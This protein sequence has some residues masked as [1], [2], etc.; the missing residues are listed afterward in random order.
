MP[1]TAL[2]SPSQLAARRKAAGGVPRGQPGG[3][4]GG[5]AGRWPRPSSWLTPLLGSVAVAAGD[6]SRCWPC[7]VIAASNGQ[8]VGR[9]PAILGLCL[10]ALFLGWGL[11][12][13]FS[14]Q[15]AL[16]SAA[17]RASEGWLALVQAGK[18]E[19]G[20]SAPPGAAV[21][22]RRSDGGQGLL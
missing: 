16:E 1:S 19:D 15:A 18:L 21:A 3:G 2:A 5:G 20:P 4:R 17:R 9:L 7:G 22:P 6:H 11:T 12:R 8:L 13:H 10:A 14:R